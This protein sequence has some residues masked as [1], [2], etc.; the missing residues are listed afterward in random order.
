MRDVEVEAT[1]FNPYVGTFNSGWDYGF[2]V[3]RGPRFQIRVVVHSER[4]WR[5]T[6]NFDYLAGGQFGEGVL[7]TGTGHQNHV[8]FVAKGDQGI[9]YVNGGRVGTADL[10]S[11]ME[12]G[13]V[14]VGTGFY[15][16]DEREGAVARYEGFKG[17]RP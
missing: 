13:R 2:F 1:F 12:A 17:K 15:D 10:S 6:K 7:N 16:G 8:R 11:H 4:Y 5:V 9:L 14:L 3:R